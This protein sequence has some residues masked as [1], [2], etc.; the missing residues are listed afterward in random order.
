MVV[1]HIP[2]A[3]CSGYHDILHSS[4]DE[5]FLIPNVLSSTILSP[6]VTVRLVKTLPELARS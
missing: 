6:S 4:V 5:N 1:L 3:L 2:L